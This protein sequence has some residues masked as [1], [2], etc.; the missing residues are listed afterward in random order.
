MTSRR[1]LSVR[2]TLLAVAL[3]AGAYAAA[4]PVYLFFRVSRPALA[5]GAATEAITTVSAVFARRDSAL[6]RAVVIVRDLARR[7]RPSADSLRLV[8]DLA[9]IGRTP[10]R[11]SAGAATPQEL[12]AALVSIDGALSRVG[13][14]LEESVAQL[15]RGR[16]ADAAAR[17]VTVEQLLRVAHERGADGSRV[18][19]A[20]LTARQ[21]ALQAAAGEVRGDAILWLGLGAL[22]VPLLVLVVRRR[23]WRPLHEL[24]A[25]LAQVADG[26]LTVSVPVRR[27]DELG[28]LAEHFN[29]MTRVLRDRAEE[30]GRFA[31]AGELLAGV[32]H[33]VNNPLMAIAAHAENRLADPAFEGEQRSEMTQILRQA[34]R[35]TKLLRGLLRFVHATDRDVTNVNLNDVVRGALDLVSY[36]FG[37]DEIT[38]GGQLDASLPPV[39]GDAIKLEQVVVNLLSNAIDALRGVTP[40]RHLS[41]DTWVRDGQVSV[42]VGDNGRGVAPDIAPRLF[43]PFATTKG[44]RGTGLGLYISRQIAREAGGDLTLTSPPGFGARFVLS[45][46][47]ALAQAPA[48]DSATSPAPAPAPAP[49]PAPALALAPSTPPSESPLGSAGGAQAPAGSLAGLRVL[50]V[51]DE[52]AVRRPMARYLRRRGAEIDEAADG[53]EGLARLR[54]QPA[55]VILA[56]LRMPRMGGVELYAQL[57]EERPE[58]AA[59]VLFLSGDVSQLAQPGNTPVPRERVLVKPVEL[60]ELERRILAFV[61]GA[62]GAGGS[63]GA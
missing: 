7:P 3:A 62:G 29:A 42:A 23:V 56:D 25:G 27:S 32:A 21:G 6:N 1:L 38:V 49:P 12:G 17:L 20:Y 44:R 59:R 37:V 58:L 36:R 15:E 33:E 45:V 54:T 8:H 43:R 22:L 13:N 2:V 10:L 57:E 11:V 5:L 35:A 4:L 60:A 53:V 19:R 30:Q 51:E 63:T 47:L 61:R 48:P 16:R 39:Q 40:P 18:A 9:A 34:R 55:N 41:V 26:D 31:A 24:E 52:E 14:V 50:I 28:R 46:P